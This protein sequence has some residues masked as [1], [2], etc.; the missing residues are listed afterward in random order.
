MACIIS[1]EERDT[2]F[3]GVANMH[4]ISDSLLIRLT[5]SKKG[6]EPYQPWVA[7]EN[8]VNLLQESSLV[9]CQGE[10]H[11]LFFDKMKPKACTAIGRK[12]LLNLGSTCYLNVIL[13][14]LVHNPLLRAHFLSD[15]HNSKSCKAKPCICCEMDRLFVEVSHELTCFVRPTTAHPRLSRY[16][17]PIQ[18]QLV[19][20]LSCIPCTSFSQISPPPPSKTPMNAS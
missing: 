6:R 8:E 19:Q 7:N 14:T 1:M 18:D 2:R 4:H 9:S 17:P 15:L 16:T 13:Q 11:N 3:Q 10:F 12:G 5:E 20:P